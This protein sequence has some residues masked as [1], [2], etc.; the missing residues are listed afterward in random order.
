MAAYGS[1]YF[2]NA[3]VKIERLALQFQPAGFDLADIENLIDQFKKMASILKNVAKEPLLLFIEWAFQLLGKQ[4]RETDDSVQGCAQFV[5]HAGEKLIFE[6]I[7]LFYLEIAGLQLLIL[8]RKFGSILLAQH[9]DAV[10]DQLPFCNVAQLLH[11][12]P[13]AIESCLLAS[14]PGVEELRLLMQLQR[15]L[16][17]TAATKPTPE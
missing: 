14:D 1:K 11:R 13:V 3:M 6:A 9:L 10:F 8:G 17:Q 7:R 16:N 12:P 4:L 2:F 15:E 5:A